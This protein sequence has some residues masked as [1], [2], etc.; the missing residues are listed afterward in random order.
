[1]SVFRSF[2][3][4][5]SLSNSRSSAQDTRYYNVYMYIIRTIYTLRPDTN[6]LTRCVFPRRL[7]TARLIET[8]LTRA[9]KKKKQEKKPEN[10][11][12][13][14][15]AV[16]GTSFRAQSAAPRREYITTIKSRRYSAGV[17]VRASCRELARIPFRQRA[18]RG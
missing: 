14:G 11:K 4:A 16:P 5:R 17:C 18:R 8:T 7:G 6:A 1:M 10:N 12:A 3:S 2:S 9:R 15:L 13:N